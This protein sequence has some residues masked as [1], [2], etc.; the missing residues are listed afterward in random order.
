MKR[1]T[2]TGQLNRLNDLKRVVVEPRKSRSTK[3]ELREFMDIVSRT[4]KGGEDNQ[5]DTLFLAVCRGK[6]SEGI[7]FPGSAARAVILVGIPYPSIKDLRVKLQRDYQDKCKKS[8]SGQDQDIKPLSGREWYQQQAFRALNQAAGRCIRHRKDWGSVIFLDSRYGNN[9]AMR[10]LPRWLRPHVKTFRG[11]GEMCETLREFV[12]RN[13]TRDNVVVEEEEEENKI[14]S[15][16]LDGDENERV[17]DETVVTKRKNTKSLLDMFRRDEEK[18]RERK[19]EKIRFICSKCRCVLCHV[20]DRTSRVT[21][22]SMMCRLNESKDFVAVNKLM[23]ED[24][25][26]APALRH[27]VGEMHH[28]WDDRDKRAYRLLCCASCHPRGTCEDA[29][30]AEV[31]GI[32]RRDDQTL[33][34]IWIFSSRVGV[35][36]WGERATKK[37]FSVSSSHNGAQKKSDEP[38]NKKNN[39][40]S[41]LKKRKKK[42]KKKT[43]E[44]ALLLFDNDSDDIFDFEPIVR[45]KKKKKTKKK[46]E[47]PTV[48]ESG[49]RV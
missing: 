47:S 12:S 21:M 31:I 45:K 37:V 29:I 30:A 18:E 3:K 41:G 5:K 15:K 9:G 44:P 46:P 1:W 2:S 40:G 10:S 24:N 35:L 16:I 33:N 42:K 26:F 49:M 48:V 20:K 39:T 38:L 14:V 8:R 17:D 7:D 34:E 19:R 4:S 13:T 6:L 22:N 36:R 27:D 11:V 28:W 43:E 23:L 25:V 32:G